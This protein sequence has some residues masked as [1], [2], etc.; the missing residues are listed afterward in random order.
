MDSNQHESVPPRKRAQNLTQRQQCKNRATENKESSS[1]SSTSELPNTW[2]PQHTA[3]RIE[4]FITSIATTLPLVLMK[5]FRS[6]PHTRHQ[7]SSK[8]S[9]PQ[10]R[11]KTHKIIF[12]CF[13]VVRN[14]NSA[15]VTCFCGIGCSKSTVRRQTN[16]AQE[17]QSKQ[18]IGNDVAFGN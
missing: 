10:D 4:K 16:G 13:L 3:C 7:S 5:K 8:N 1:Q 15:V 14:T 18:R 17:L 12:S 11:K 6:N 2:Y 9:P